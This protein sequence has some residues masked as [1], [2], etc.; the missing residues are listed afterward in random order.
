MYRQK[1]TN[2]EIHTDR[3]EQ[4][5]RQTRIRDKEFVTPRDPPLR[6]ARPGTPAR[7]RGSRDRHRVGR[8]YATDTMK[9]QD[10]VHR[11][12]GCVRKGRCRGAPSMLGADIGH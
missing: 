3:Q 8:R 10:S 12:S 2:L 4:R 6:H 11:I 7:P 9:M 1:K 5:E